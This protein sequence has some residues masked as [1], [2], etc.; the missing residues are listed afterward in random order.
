MIVSQ[1]PLIGRLV[2][3]SMT[4]ISLVFSFF[5]LTTHALLYFSW[6]D[7]MLVRPVRCL[8]YIS[9][10]VCQ[11]FF[12]ISCFFFRKIHIFAKGEQSPVLGRGS[13]GLGLRFP[14]REEK[15]VVTGRRSRQALSVDGRG[16]GRIEQRHNILRRNPGLDVVDRGTN[17]SP[18]GREGFHILLHLAGNFV[19]LL[20]G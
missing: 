5:S 9:K 10:V 12:I 19:G 8:Y 16:S 7:H 17:V 11:V 14:C 13:S 1:C 4:R 6:Y 18:A 15:V 20:K 3:L 2:V